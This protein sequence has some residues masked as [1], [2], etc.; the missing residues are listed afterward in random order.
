[1]AAAGKICNSILL[2]KGK[3]CTNGIKELE[4]VSEE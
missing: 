2:F 4:N 1:M 3:R